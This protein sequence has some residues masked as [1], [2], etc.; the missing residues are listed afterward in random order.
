MKRSMLLVAAVLFF[1]ILSVSAQ[2]QN[3]MFVFD[4]GIFSVNDSVCSMEIYYSFFPGAF[5]RLDGA[6]GP[7]VSGNF[8]IMVNDATADT[9][10]IKR[11]Y[12]FESPFSDTSQSTLIGTVN[13]LLPFGD[14]KASIK[15]K[16]S[17]DTG[18]V[19]GEDFTFSVKPYP[20]ERF[21]ISSLQMASS[22]RES[23]NTQSPYYKNTYEVIPHPSLVY[24]ESIPLFFYAEIYNVND[25]VNAEL[26]KVEHLLVDSRNNVAYKKNKFISRKNPDIVEAGVINLKKIPSGTYTFIL[27]VSDT[28]DKYTAAI[29]KKV[30][31][32][33]PHLIDTN[34]TQFT[35][36]DYTSSE[37]AAMSEAEIE[38][39]FESSKYIAS[40]AELAQWK[41]FTDLKEK[42]SFL[43]NFWK[44]RDPDV[45]T[46]ENEFK[47]TYSRRLEDANNKFGTFQK[48]GWKTDRGRVYCQ[49]G[50]PSEIERYPNQVDSKP[51]EMWRYDEI[52]GGVVFVFADLTGFDD[53]LL[54]H[55]TMRGEL[56]DDNWTRRIQ[57]F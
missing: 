28:L 39:S 15:A 22:I 24:G 38:E 30:Y 54:I 2:T 10:V 26:L 43:Y 56:R 19:K 18:Y 48:K 32:Y 52:E 4:Y 1:F 13:F 25:Q 37:F 12:Q 20:K 9:L 34:V 45:S 21:S 31:V 11:E 51:F 29:S 35:G 33:N 8:I 17:S 36:M 49:Y 50:Q 27:A 16:N 46:V 41:K 55:S 57:A 7:T 53:Y 47:K 23:E 44:N 6:N 14:Y 5:I 42:Q 40:E 3:D